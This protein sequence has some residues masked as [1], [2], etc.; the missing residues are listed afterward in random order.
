MIKVTITRTGTEKINS[1]E[2]SGHAFY[3]DPGHD[4]VCA[5]VSAVSVGTVNAVHELTGVEP[6]IETRN[7]FLRCVVPENLPEDIHEKV[8]LLLEG[9]VVQLR[10]IEEQYGKNIKITFKK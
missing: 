4:I 9:M 6:E 3:G 5:G 8:Q 1:F 10:S 7:G 2:I